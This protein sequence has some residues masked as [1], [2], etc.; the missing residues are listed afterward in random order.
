[1]MKVLV[2]F[3]KIYAQSDLKALAFAS[4]G[5]NTGAQGSKKKIANRGV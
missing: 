5:E 1:M 3:R 2:S 4:I